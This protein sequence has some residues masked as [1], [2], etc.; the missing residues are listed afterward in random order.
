M[1]I[2]G[3]VYL[4]CLVSYF[5]TTT[6][7]LPGSARLYIPENSTEAYIGDFLLDGVRIKMDSPLRNEYGNLILD[8]A[9]KLIKY[10]KSRGI[11]PS[12][13]VK[14]YT[15]NDEDFGKLLLNDAYAKNLVYS[16]P[17]KV[18]EAPVNYGIPVG[19]SVPPGKVLPA[20]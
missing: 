12:N 9:G 8:N 5:W 1:I 3:A 14:C 16:P 6:Y 4:F 7:D 13:S 20:H 18:I 17:P 11:L 10:C 15:H 2:Y 19:V